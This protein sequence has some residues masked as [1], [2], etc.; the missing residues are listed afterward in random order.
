[1]NTARNHQL[2]SRVH[3]DDKVN[4]HSLAHSMNISTIT[5]IHKLVLLRLQFPFFNLFQVRKFC[6]INFIDAVT[7]KPVLIVISAYRLG[8]VAFLGSLSNCY[9]EK[10]DRYD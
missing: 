3:V 10:N 7:L 2:Q 8:V 9:A 4:Q 5:I 1:M 6:R